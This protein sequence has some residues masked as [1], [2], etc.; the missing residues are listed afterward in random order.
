MLKM[1]VELHKFGLF[2]EGAIFEASIYNNMTSGDPDIGNY[3]A[4]YRMLVWGKEQE[5]MIYIDNHERQKPVVYLIEQMCQSIIRE[6]EREG[7]ENNGPT[8]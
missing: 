8:V 2:D 4:H 7:D 6:I 5:G 1:Q 3:V